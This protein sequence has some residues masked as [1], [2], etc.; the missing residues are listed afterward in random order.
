MYIVDTGYINMLG[1]SQES[2]QNYQGE[3]TSLNDLQ[4]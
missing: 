4:T 2:T 1:N 3:Y